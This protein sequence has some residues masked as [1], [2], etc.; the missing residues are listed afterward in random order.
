MKKPADKILY[1]WDLAN[2]LFP[3]KW[4]STKSGFASHKAYTVSLGLDPENPRDYEES[5]KEPYVRGDW[6]TLGIADGYREVLTW[7]KNNEA[8]T[9]GFREQMDWRAEYLNPRVGYDIRK[10]L[11]KITSTFDYAETNLK[12]K[13]MLV[14]FLSKKV[15]EGYQTVV[16]TD[17]KLANCQFFKEAAEIVRLTSPAFN[18]RVYHLTNSLS[19]VKKIGWYWEIGKL[20]DILKNEKILVD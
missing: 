18:Y 19:H 3:E 6:Y 4:D 15:Q 12:T 9:T 13:E 14:D 11:Q 10:Y 7:A 1:L 8:F 17:D 2:T 20:L 16:Y 5:V